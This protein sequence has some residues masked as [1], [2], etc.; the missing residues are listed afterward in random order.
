[1]TRPRVRDVLLVAIAAVIT[2]GLSA[3]AAS[4]PGSGE[5]PQAAQGSEVPT[6][7][8]SE[9]VDAE[10]T[11]PLGTEAPEAT[12]KPAAPKPPKPAKAKKTDE[13]PDAKAR[14]SDEDASAHGEAVSAAARGETEPVGDCRNHGHWVSTV[15]K[16]LA[17]CDDNPRPAGGGPPEGRGGPPEGRGGPPEGRGGPPPGRGPGGD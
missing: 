2:S 14:E 7:K 6:Q 1:M 5:L 16:G 12:E 3:F 8:P 4:G 10:P 13:A 11:K 15:A 9:S 17:S